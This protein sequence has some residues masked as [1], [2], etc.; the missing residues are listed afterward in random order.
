[1]GKTILPKEGKRMKESSLKHKT[2]SKATLS[3]LP[4]YYRYLTD[5]ASGLGENI[6]ATK[7]SQALHMGE[8]QVRKD[9][10][11]ASGIGKPK[12]GY[13]T[14]QLIESL[15]KYLGYNEATPVVL[16]GVGKL[17]AAL[18]KYTDFATY[19]LKIVAAFDADPAKVG[20]SVAG[21]PV[22]NASELADFCKNNQV[23]IGVIT[24]PAA[25][26]Q[27]VCDAMTDCGIKAIWNLAPVTLRVSNDVRLMQENLALSIAFLNMQTKFPQW[28]EEE[29]ETL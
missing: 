20:K 22:K 2:A 26:A 8:I 14:Q 25:A 23:H 19:G 15:E 5:P 10:G 1:M 3:R 12:V 28:N 27:S 11:L 13:K 6:S 29:K 17:G 9:L 16:M 18:L 7:I 24:T 21:V 4:L